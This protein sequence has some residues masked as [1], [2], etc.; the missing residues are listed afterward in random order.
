[1]KNVC[2][3]W[4][5]CYHSAGKFYLSSSEIA[6]DSTIDEISYENNKTIKIPIDKTIIE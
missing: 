1:M 6:G 2:K 3:Q 5:G 4:Y